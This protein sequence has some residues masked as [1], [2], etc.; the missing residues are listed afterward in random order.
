MCLGVPMQITELDGDKAVVRLSGVSREVSLLLV[1][2][3][4]VGDY[5]LVHAGFAISIIDEQIAE[6]TLELLEEKYGDEQADVA[7]PSRISGDSK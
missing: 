6:E 1:E 7:D 2:N 5:V 4:R 3:A